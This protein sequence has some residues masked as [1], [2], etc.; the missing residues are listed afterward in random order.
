MV[1]SDTSSPYS[2][3][4][5]FRPPPDAHA[6]RPI[7]KNERPTELACDGKTIFYKVS[8]TVAHS[9]CWKSFIQLPEYIKSYYK[10]WKEVRNEKN[11]IE[12]HRAAYGLPNKLIKLV[13]YIRGCIGIV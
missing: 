10:M 11:S 7:L 4:A 8:T 12:Q 1:A 13:P 6:K 3:R 2:R 5:R 9:D